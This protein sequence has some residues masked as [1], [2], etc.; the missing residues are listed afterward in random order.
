MS[1]RREIRAVQAGRL[2][3]ADSG[4][5]LTLPQ[6]QGLAAKPRIYRPEPLDAYPLLH[7]GEVGLGGDSAT[8]A[9]GFSEEGVSSEPFSQVLH[10]W[11]LLQLAQHKSSEITLWAV[12]DG[13]PRSFT[14]ETLP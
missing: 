13:S 7:L 1:P 3:Q 4:E 12:L 11:Y 10:V 6:S 9:A 2:N 5:G 8:V 14:V